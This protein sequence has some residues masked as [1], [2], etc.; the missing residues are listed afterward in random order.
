MKER[1]PVAADVQ[2]A[3]ATD[4]DAG[5][6]DGFAARQA[7]AS[8]YHVW[9]W[10]RVVEEAFGHECVYLVAREG[11]VVV[12]V[13]PLVFIRSRL[14]GRSMT[15]L[16][17]L[18][19]GGVLAATTAAASALLDAAGTAARSRQCGHV[20]LRHVARRF[21]ALPCR[22]HKVTMLLEVAP[23][24]WERLDRKVRNQVRKGEKS[25]LSAT[26]GGLELVGEFYA[27]FARNMR[28]LG[29]PVY[30]RRF[31]EAVLRHL[32]GRAHLHVVRLGKT[33]VA[34]GLT[35]QSGQVVEVPWASSVRDYNHLCANHLLYWHII[36]AAIADGRTT[37]DFG[38]STPG[39]GTFKFKAQW[40]A[41]PVPLHWEYLL[42]AGAEVPDQSPKN[43]K[44]QLAISAWKRLPLWLANAVGP[45]I[46]RGIP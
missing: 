36:E 2:V 8:G 17:F 13:L 3:I 15:S 35:F 4:A 18:N 25:G 40:G 5:E 19:Y 41:T 23:G 33:P 31:F 14:F 26:R 6:W 22:Q 11:S 24:H 20:E 44:F 29:T 46:V 38:R 27:V 43:P 10:R 37:L 42:L 12:G 7:P 9:A 21:P 34:A 1:E 16:P 28:D 45:H 39:E 30:G 32:A